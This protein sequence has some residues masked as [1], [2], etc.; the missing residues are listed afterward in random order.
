MWPVTHQWGEFGFC[1]GNQCGGPWC[2]SWCARCYR[3]QKKQRKSIP[4]ESGL[5][6]RAFVYSWLCDSLVDKGMYIYIFYIKR[7]HQIDW[8][9]KNLG[10]V[11]VFPSD[12]CDCSIPGAKSIWASEASAA[13]KG[14]MGVVRTTRIVFWRYSKCTQ[15]MRS[16]NI[17]IVTIIVFIMFFILFISRCSSSSSWSSSLT[18][19]KMVSSSSPLDIDPPWSTNFQDQSCQK[20][21]EKMPVSPRVPVVISPVPHL[22]SYNLKF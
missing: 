20:T 22:N 7:L 13:W 6:Q 5:I 14:P 12:A 3:R 4:L 2:C 16:S 19:P 11:Q 21:S 17:I 10:A 9:L 18:S 8:N 15:G 1:A